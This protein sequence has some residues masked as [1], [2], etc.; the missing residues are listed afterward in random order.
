MSEW[1]TW[2]LLAILVTSNLM[3]TLAALWVVYV[4]RRIDG[5]DAVPA[6]GA[7]LKGAKK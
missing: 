6:W 5:D 1:W 2:W 4:M 7:R 3:S